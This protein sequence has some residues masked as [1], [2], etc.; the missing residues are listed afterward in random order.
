MKSK[1][2]V[3]ETVEVIEQLEEE[4]IDLEVV[5]WFAGEG[6]ASDRRQQRLQRLQHERGD[7]L[8][9]DLLFAL[10]G[11]RYPRREALRAWNAI[12][13]HR[14]ELERVLKRNPG[15]VVA[16][17]DWVTNLQ[18]DFSLGLSLIET[19]KLEN[20]LERAVVDGLTGMYDH[21]TLMTLLEKEVERARRHAESIAVLMLDLDDFKQVNDELGH[22]KGDE[23]LARTAD[24]MRA[25]VR[26][27]DMPG[28]YGGEEFAVILPETDIAAA[29]QS[30]ERL[31]CAVEAGFE[32]DIGLTVSVGAAC[33]PQHAATVETLIRSADEALYQAKRAGKNRIA[34]AQA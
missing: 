19:G 12:V 10:F 2:P 31:R 15:I 13:E 17:L 14:D 34:S 3:Q 28:R 29:L 6:D 8:Y 27:M 11:Q 7:R 23:V 33:F 30:A 18:D 4:Q 26:T 24:I 9:S 1:T 21:D 5:R 20:M 32:R 25:T 16:A 22:Q